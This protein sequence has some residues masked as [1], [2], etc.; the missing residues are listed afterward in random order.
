M[1]DIIAFYPYKFNQLNYICMMQQ[2]IAEKYDVVAY[3]ELKQR[4]YDMSSIRTIYLN[5]IE[6]NMTE[7]DRKVL[8]KARLYGKKVVWVF[9]NKIQHDCEDREQLI[10]NIQYLIKYSTH[11]IIHCKKSID[12]LREY[13][14][15]INLGKLYFIP[16]VNFIGD[17]GNY[18][19]I[20]KKLSINSDEFV[21]GMFGLIRPYKNIELCIEAFKRLD[22]SFKCKLIIAGKPLNREY[23]EKL[24]KLA[25]T[26]KRICLEP[27][28]CS[29]IEMASY[30]HASDVVVLPYD[31]RSGLNSGVMIMAFS[32][33][34]TVI[35]SDIGMAQEYEETL[36]YRYAYLDEEDHIRQLKNQM[37]KAYLAGKEKNNEMGTKLFDIVNENNSKEKVREQL[38]CLV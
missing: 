26:D 12:Y 17:Y 9:H 38:L 35:V 4:L 34:T 24:E 33:G 7:T 27:Q 19:N 16:H 25:S 15:N 23:V 8:K 30:L 5:W 20:T 10:S 37:E 18:N 36:I 13:S 2:F 22:N 1:K 28:Y 11:I 14:P 32:Y 29:D 31:V 6:N 21:F 3:E